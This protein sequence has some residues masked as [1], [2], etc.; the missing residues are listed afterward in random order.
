MPP[1]ITIQRRMAMSLVVSFFMLFC[2]S[3][4]FGIVPVDLICRK[5][6]SFFFR[7]SAG[8]CMKCALPGSVAEK[9]IQHRSS[10]I[11]EIHP[12]CQILFLAYK[13]PRRY[14]KWERMK[15]ENGI[16]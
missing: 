13:H 2:S 10:E 5:S 7:N 4:F 11:N 8:R 12:K 14:K 3:H 1:I 6:P 16:F 9:I 15:S